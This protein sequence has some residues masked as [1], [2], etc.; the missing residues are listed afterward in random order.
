MF[1]RA[2]QIGVGKSVQEEAGRER[3]GSWEGQGAK[4]AADALHGG[5]KRQEDLREEPA[6]T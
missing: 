2:L 3:P 6:V 4:G 1:G 5:C